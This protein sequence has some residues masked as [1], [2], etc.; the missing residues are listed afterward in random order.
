M[1]LHGLLNGPDHPTVIAAN[2]RAVSA[3]AMRALAHYRERGERG[4]RA[5]EAAVAGGH[6]QVKRC[7]TLLELQVLLSDSLDPRLAWLG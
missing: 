1:L 2:R 5:A 7:A 3:M 6:A 4:A